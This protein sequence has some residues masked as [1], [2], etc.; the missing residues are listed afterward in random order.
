MLG[1]AATE[2]D[3]ASAGAS[4]TEAT[5]PITDAAETSF[6]VTEATEA[7][8]AS[9]TELL[10]PGIPTSQYFGAFW[11]EAAATWSAL[12]KYRKPTFNFSASMMQIVKEIGVGFAT[13]AEVKLR[14]AT[15]RRPIPNHL[16]HCIAIALY[17]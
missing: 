10:V 3:E 17:L 4:T 6:E 13:D 11:D 8:E 14:A 5:Q 7:T 15:Q 16:P 9:E 12:H 2:S 1:V